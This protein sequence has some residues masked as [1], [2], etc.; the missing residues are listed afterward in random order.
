MERPFPAGWLSRFALVLWVLSIPPLH[1]QTLTVL[2]SFTKAID[3]FVPAGGVIR[4]SAGNLYGAT[5]SGGAFTWGAVYELNSSGQESVLYSLMAGTDGSVPTAGLVRDSAGNLFGTTAFGGGTTACSS[6][7][8]TVFKVDST[9]DE[10]VLYRFAG[11]PDGAYP[12]GLIPPETCT[13]PP[14]SAAP[15]AEG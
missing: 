9:G 7:C 8:G 13:E 12:Q 5:V 14:P 15:A 4:D 3:G 6:G 11:A 1:A 10:T 2:Y